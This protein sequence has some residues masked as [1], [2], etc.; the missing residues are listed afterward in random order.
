MDRASCLELVSFDK[1]GERILNDGVY[2]LI[3]D[4]VQSELE[5]RAPT[6]EQVKEDLRYNPNHLDEYLRLNRTHHVS[7]VDVG[8]ITANSKSSAIE[9]E[10]ISKL[11]QN[12]SELR[13]FERFSE[14]ASPSVV[15]MW[16][17]SLVVLLIFAAHN[18]LAIYTTLYQT[19][20]V[21][22]IISY[23]IWVGLGVGL[24]SVLVKRHNR[25]HEEYK[26]TLSCVVDLLREG[27][28][29]G[30]LDEKQLFG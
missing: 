19:R 12:L 8:E 10:S 17:G 18:V 28:R 16:V 15:G 26:T 1:A 3:L 24:H 21:S 22:V 4:E 20:M 23:L 25:S 11:N 13:A 30:W 5:G 14:T 27:K 29:E 9:K 7:C 2:S 6:I